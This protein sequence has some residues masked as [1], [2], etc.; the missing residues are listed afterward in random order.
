MTA[1]TTNPEQE[2]L[3]PFLKENGY[4]N[5][6]VLDDGT[7]VGTLDL[8]YTRSLLIGLNEWSW[9]R[10]YC[11]EHRE[12][13]NVAVQLIATGDDEPLPGYVAQ[14]TGMANNPRKTA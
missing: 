5:L 8:I 1:P 4:Q 2:S 6:R 13:A 12:L 3:L 9:E 7:I 11:Y 10:R 14:R